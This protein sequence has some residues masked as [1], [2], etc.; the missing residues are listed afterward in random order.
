MIEFV[1]ESER[2]IKIMKDGETV[3]QIFTPSGSCHDVENAI[4]I[5]GFSE[6]FDFWGC[7]RFEGFKDI[8]LLFDDRKMGGEFNEAELTKCCRCFM[9]PCQCESRTGQPFFVKS[10]NWLEDRI[11]KLP[12]PKDNGMNTT[13][14]ENEANPPFDKK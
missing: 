5:C 9:E 8:Q 12:K 1:L 14:N 10:E 6:A 4:Q 2:S 11:Q 3:G 13:W 7:G